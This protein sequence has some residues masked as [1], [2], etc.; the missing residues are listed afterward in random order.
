[1]SDAFLKPFNLENLMKG[2]GPF[3]RNHLDGGLPS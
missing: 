3:V 2:K 1:M